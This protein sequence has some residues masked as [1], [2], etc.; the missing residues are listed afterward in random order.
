[1]NIKTIEIPTCFGS[2]RDHH[3]GA[4]SCLDK[5]TITILLCSSL[6]TWS[7]L[8]RHSSLLCKRAVPHPCTIVGTIKFSLIPTLS[9]TPTQR[10]TSHPMTQKT[11]E[12]PIKPPAF[13]IASSRTK[14]SDIF[15][16][17]LMID[18]VYRTPHVKLQCNR[19]RSK[20]NLPRPSAYFAVHRI[21]FQ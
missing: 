17:M 19:L 2:R 16:M 21:T 6:I 4:I 18:D 14:T 13:K 1:M 12:N 8:W 7:M 10:T 15:L 9:P 20:E 3:Q 11:M 5:T